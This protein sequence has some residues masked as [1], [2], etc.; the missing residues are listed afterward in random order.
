MISFNDFSR[1]HCD[2]VDTADEGVKNAIKIRENSSCV[3]VEG[4]LLLK[5]STIID[6][7]DEKADDVS[8]VPTFI[9]AG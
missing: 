9:I 3:N 8:D 7:K 1:V 4:K 5:I 2:F 6:S